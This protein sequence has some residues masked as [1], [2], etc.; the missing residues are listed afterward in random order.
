[1]LARVTTSRAAGVARVTTRTTTSL[2][3]LS[4]HFLNQV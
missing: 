4:K 3:L 1:V 2:F